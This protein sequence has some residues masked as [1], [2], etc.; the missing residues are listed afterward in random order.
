MKKI[1]H[2]IL[3][4][5]MTSLLTTVCVEANPSDIYLD[6]QF[7]WWKAHEDGIPLAADVDSA[8]PGNVYEVDWG[9]DPG[10]RIGIGGI[11]SCEW[12]LFLSYTW[13]RTRAKRESNANLNTFFSIGLPLPPAHLGDFAL[14]FEN[15]DLSLTKTIFGNEIFSFAPLFAIKGAMIKD[16]YNVTLIQLPVIFRTV[17]NEEKFCGIGP[18]LG[19]NSSWCL[20][21][22]ITLV[23]DAGFSLLWGAQSVHRI[24]RSETG[25]GIRTDSIHAHTKTLRFATCYTL[26][27]Q[28][29]TT[30]CDGYP[31]RVLA[32]WEQQQWFNSNQIFYSQLFFDNLLL[33][34]NTDLGLYGFTLKADLLF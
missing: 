20:I 11:F 25:G 34:R 19:F 4:C 1:T 33:N 24:E 6:G 17:N 18:T 30:L 12:D 10:Y 32:A 15:I 14:K 8:S 31:L 16:V 23:A 13:F 9:W 28:W 27:L 21:K 3:L 22:N 29:C 5:L 26:G 7:L 2:K